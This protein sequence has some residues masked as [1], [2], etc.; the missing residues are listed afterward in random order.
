MKKLSCTNLLQSIG[1]LYDAFVR[2]KN[3]VKI[4][5]F[6]HF[7]NINQVGA[8]TGDIKNVI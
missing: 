7:W 3:D 5:S 8:E 4:K 1:P 2:V 6:G